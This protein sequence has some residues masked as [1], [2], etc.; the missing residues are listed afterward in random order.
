MLEGNRINGKM[1]GED[2]GK[3]KLAI[4]NKIFRVEFAEVLFEP[5]LETAEG[6]NPFGYWR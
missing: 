6:V 5:R 2:K 4:L 1:I 3:S